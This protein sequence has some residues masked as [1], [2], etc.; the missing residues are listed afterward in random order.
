MPINGKIRAVH[1]LKLLLKM[2]TELRNILS[3]VTLCDNMITRRHDDKM[4]RQSF[5]RKK[6]KQ[7]GAGLCQAQNKFSQIVFD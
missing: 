3:T 1:F 5:L 4:T 2:L 6:I 7:A